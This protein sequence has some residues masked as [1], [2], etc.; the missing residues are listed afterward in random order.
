CITSPHEGAREHTMLSPLA[1]AQAAPAAVTRLCGARRADRRERG[2]P[3]EG[4]KGATRGAMR[5]VEKAVCISYTL[6]LTSRPGRSVASFPRLC[7]RTRAA[8]FVSN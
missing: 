5:A 1:A 3:R 2:H 6:F 8:R 4:V 7:S